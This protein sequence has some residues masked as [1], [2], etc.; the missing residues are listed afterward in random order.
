MRFFITVV[1]IGVP[2]SMHSSVET[3]SLDYLAQK[4][5]EQNVS[6]RE[7]PESLNLR[8]LREEYKRLSKMKQNLINSIDTANKVVNI[9]ILF[10]F[11]IFPPILPYFVIRFLKCVS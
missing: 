6:L 9:L 8:N 7:S 2:A 5:H 4:V 10:Y 3:I 1:R 11:I